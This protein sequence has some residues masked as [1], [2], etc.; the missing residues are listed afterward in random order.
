MGH[1][2]KNMSS[3]DE[4][5][6]D[7]VDMPVVRKGRAWKFVPDKTKELIWTQIL[8]TF[9]VP[10]TKAMKKHWMGEKAG[11]KD[12]GGRAAANEGSFPIRSFHC[13]PG[14][15]RPPRH[16]N[17]KLR[18]LRVTNTSMKMFF[19]VASKI[20]ILSTAI[21]KPDYPDA[22]RG[23]TRGALPSHGSSF[24]RLILL[25]CGRHLRWMNKLRAY[26]RT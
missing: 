7:M 2:V 19:A 4:S 26:F 16:K 24:G 8:Q 1:H 13:Y 6:G 14:P 20:D 17:G 5:S 3:S 23:E 21:G 10:N 12:D 18:G 9:D 15:Q 11:T 25:R 22:V